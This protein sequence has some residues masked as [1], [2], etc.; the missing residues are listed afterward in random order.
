MISET[1]VGA[2]HCG[3][4]G[5]N[6][7]TALPPTAWEIRACQ[8]GF[9]RAHAALSTSDPAGRVEFIEREPDSMKRYR[10]A[11]R[12]ADFLV[13]ATCG[14]YVGAVM[15]TPRGWFGIINV[16]ALRPAPP[17]L[18]QT[19]AMIYDAESATERLARREARW[20]PVTRQR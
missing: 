2:C 11:T 8:C 3:A 19:T 17:G 18:A 15:K 7:L 1:Y 10:F 16:R 6:Y 12:T 13:C 14:V 9:C 5:F 4:I 20:M